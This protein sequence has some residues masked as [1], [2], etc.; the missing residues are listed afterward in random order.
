MVK[1]ARKSDLEPALSP[2]QRRM[3][4]TLSLEARRKLLAAQAERM[5]AHYEQESEQSERDAWQGG[6]IVD[7]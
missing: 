6:D 4:M 2:A 3:Y 5:V 7:P 1:H